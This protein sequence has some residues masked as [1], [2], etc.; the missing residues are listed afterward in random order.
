MSL[1]YNK[2]EKERKERERSDIS[3][4]GERKSWERRRYWRK[5]G[6]EE[7]EKNFV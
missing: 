2:E 1:K 4:N 6:F 5:S 7:R 3:Q